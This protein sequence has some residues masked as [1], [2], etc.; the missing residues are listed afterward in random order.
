MPSAVIDATPPP[1]GFL[2]CWRHKSFVIGALLTALLAG[3]AL[4][5]LCGRPIRRRR[6]TFPPSCSRRRLSHWLGTDSLGRDIASPAPGGLAE[7]RSSWA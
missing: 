7:H 1:R 3:M 6:S 4:L 2:G 5:S